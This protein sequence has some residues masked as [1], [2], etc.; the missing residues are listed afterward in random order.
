[1]DDSNIVRPELGLFVLFGTSGPRI[2]VVWGSRG[3]KTKLVFRDQ[4]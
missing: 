3:P 4:G 1:M 2:K